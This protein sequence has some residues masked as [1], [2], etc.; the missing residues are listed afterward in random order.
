MRIIRP[1]RLARTLALGA[2]LAFSAAVAKADTLAGALVDAYEYSGLLDQNRALLR[3]ADEDVA[4]AMTALR[5]VINWSASASAGYSETDI[6]TVQTTN[7][8]IGI[9]SQLLIY[10]GGASQLAIEAQKETVLATR[11]QLIQ[12][13]Q[14]VLLRAIQAYLNVRREAAFLNLRQNNVRVITQE[15]RAARDRF[16]VGEVTRTDVSLAEA[17]L[18]SARSLLAAAEGSLAQAAEEFRAVTGRAPGQLDAPGGAAIPY[19]LA[20]AKAYAVRNHP[21]MRAAQHNV[22]AAELNI[23]RGEAAMEPTVNFS[24]QIGVDKDF[25]DSASIGLNASGPIYQG[26]RLSSQVR[27][28]M[29][30]RDAAR[31]ALHVTRVGIEQNVAN[32]FAALAVSRA[33]STAF[34]QQVNASE[35]AFRGVREEATLGART[36]IDV[37]NA[38]QELLDARA[39]LISAQVDEILASYQVLFSMGLLTAENLRLG[40]QTYDPV[41]YY[42]LVE[43]APAALSAQG[44]ALDRVLRAIGD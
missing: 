36:T 12:V 2:A 18:A 6:G 40:V 26:G 44:Q 33:S 22:A 39:N 16:E 25:N 24:A 23:R 3:A 9:S 17:R 10:D 19:T 37:L 41:A 28:F 13:E 20:E 27:R 14:Q 5:P 1:A 31:A 8:N 43:D 42:N 21:D 11:Q 15:L 7:A 30:Q 34:S 32:A 38:E 29:A 4:I 35:I